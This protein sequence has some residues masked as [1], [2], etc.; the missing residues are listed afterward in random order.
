MMN[1]KVVVFDENGMFL[2][3][4]VW[5]LPRLSHQYRGAVPVD[6]HKAVSISTM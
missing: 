1:V 4:H 2:S 6:G 3:N 5:I